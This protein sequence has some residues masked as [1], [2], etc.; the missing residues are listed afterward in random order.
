MEFLR[1]IVSS[2]LCYLLR[3]FVKRSPVGHQWAVATCSNMYKQSAQAALL[4]FALNYHAMGVDEKHHAEQPRRCRS[5]R[6][7]QSSY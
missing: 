4:P 5:L 6:P 3:L 1:S 2:S 7:T